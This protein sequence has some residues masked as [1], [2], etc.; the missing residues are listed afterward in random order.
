MW[1][2]SILHV[3]MV[4]G[5]IRNGL[6]EKLAVKKRLMTELFTLAEWRRLF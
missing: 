1:G 4:T 5:V 3:R 6:V 2:P